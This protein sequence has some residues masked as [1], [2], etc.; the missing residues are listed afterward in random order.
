MLGEVA[1]SDESIFRNRLIDAGAL[2]AAQEQRLC[3]KRIKLKDTRNCKGSR[4]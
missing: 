2:L 4:T 3:G 1:V